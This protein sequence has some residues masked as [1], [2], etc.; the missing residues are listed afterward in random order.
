MKNQTCPRCGSGPGVIYPQHTEWKCGSS[1]FFGQSEECRFKARKKAIKTTPKEKCPKCGA[2]ETATSRECLSLS[3][4]WECGSKEILVGQTEQSPKCRIR[5]LELKIET[6]DD[7]ELQDAKEWIID[8][9]S[10]NK[11]LNVEN[12]NLKKPKAY[13]IDFWIKPNTD[14]N[15]LKKELE[16]ANKW[17]I[18]LTKQI[19]GLNKDTKNL[20]ETSDWLLDVIMR[21][22]KIS[23]CPDKQKLVDLVKDM[24]S[25]IN[26]YSNY[27]STNLS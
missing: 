23:K 5:E 8:L 2:E 6:Y 11:R 22:R 14:Y 15:A 9:I 3:I 17:I 25:A 21:A 1:E 20:T 18:G 19:K 10:E 16:N 4:M 12:T 13:G 26:T 27:F 7:E 24:R